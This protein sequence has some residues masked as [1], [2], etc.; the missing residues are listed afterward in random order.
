M[1][2]IDNLFKNIRVYG[3]DKEA[4]MNGDFYPSSSS[5]LASVKS[6]DDCQFLLTHS[7]NSYQTIMDSAAA[8]G[9]AL[10]DAFESYFK[11]TPI[12]PT[13]DLAPAYQNFLGLV[14]K[15]KIQANTTEMEVVSEKYGYAGTLDFIGLF[16]DELALIDWKTGTRFD[17]KYGW[18]MASYAR[19]YEEPNPEKNKLDRVIGVQIP[20][21]GRAPKIFKYEHVDSCFEA[22]LSAL[23]TFRMVYFNDLRKLDWRYLFKNPLE[24]YYEDYFKTIDLT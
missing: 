15:H 17:I 14:D 12:V 20:R 19:A 4:I 24:T 21:T 18:Q 7:A 8:K 6:Y 23:N 5:I 13:P 3:K 1:L 11:G 10:H 22:F 2:R 9:V 16:D